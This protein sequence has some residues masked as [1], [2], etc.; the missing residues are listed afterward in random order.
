VEFGFGL[1]PRVFGKKRGET[2]YSLNLLPIGGFVKLLG[3]DETDKGALSNKRSFVQ[4]NVWARMSVVVAGVVMNLLLALLIFSYTTFSQGYK[5]DIPLLKPYQFWGVTQVN[6]SVIIVQATSKD[7]PAEQS[8]LKKDDK[9]VS[10]NGATLQNSDQLIKQTKEHA[11]QEVT[12]GVTDLEDKNLHTVSLIPRTNP[13]AG[14]GA[15]GLELGSLDVATLTYPTATQKM[16][17]GVIHGSNLAMYSFSLLGDLIRTSFEKKDLAPVSDSVAGPIGITRI[18]NLVLQTKNPLVPYLEF[19][20]GL[21]LNL[22]IF[23]I[24]PFPAL[25][26]GRLLFL[27]IEAITRKRVKAE[28]EKYIHT[29]G[30]AFLLALMLLITFSDLKKFLF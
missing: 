23:N 27:L 8:G 26:G 1:P 13:P 18:A 7:S 24:L 25:D 19:M 6:K 20:G 5:E 28:V 17:S 2:I 11:G 29:A 12:L 15:L 4:K 9:I 3:E 21:S 16:F 22:A 30:M 10:F 14:Q